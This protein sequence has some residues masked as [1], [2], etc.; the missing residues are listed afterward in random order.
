MAIKNWIIG[1]P[2]S[3]FLVF[4]LR[5]KR[6]HCLHLVYTGAVNSLKMY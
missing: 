4:N 3:A 5:V 1:E 2:I 6:V